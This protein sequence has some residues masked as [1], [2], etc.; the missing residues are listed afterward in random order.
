M[1]RFLLLLC[2]FLCACGQPEPYRVRKNLSYGPLPEQTFD[3]YEPPY[4][5]GLGR[6]L[7]IAIHGGAWQSGDKVWG[8]NIAEQ[9]CWRGFTVASI[10]YR[11][12]PDHPWPAQIEDCQLALQYFQQ[13]AWMRINNQRIAA[14]GHSAGGHLATM[15]LF[16]PP[17][18][19]FIPDVPLRIAI[20]ASG[21]SDLIRLRD[22]DKN[23]NALLQPDIPY[24]FTQEQLKDV[25]PINFINNSD[26]TSLLLI[27]ATG[28]TNVI[29]DHSLLLYTDLLQHGGDVQLRTLFSGNHNR[30]YQDGINTAIRFLN[31]RGMR[32][33]SR[34]E[35]EFWRYER[36]IDEIR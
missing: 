1:P 33:S 28:D 20:S 30:S 26:N 16:R 10:N 25:S 31:A 4:H 3:F 9:L 18:K 2:L 12:A 27:H 6:P 22:Q 5:T 13:A 11:L 8:R 36:Q 32:P 17:G 29:Y 14:F 34:Q 23:L 7:I 24:T 19:N 21:E 15:L 35:K